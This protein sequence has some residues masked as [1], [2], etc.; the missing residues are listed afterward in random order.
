MY[1]KPKVT[2]LF[3]SDQDVIRTSDGFGGEWSDEN[4]DQEGWA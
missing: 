1:E 2:I 4:V 3:F